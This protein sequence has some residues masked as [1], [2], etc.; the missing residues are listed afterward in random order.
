MNK[1]SIARY[2]IL[3]TISVASV[4]LLFGEYSAES[5][6]AYI[7][8]NILAKAAAVALAIAGWRLYSEWHP[9]LDLEEDADDDCWL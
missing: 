8:V 5:D 2:F 3:L 6:A 1:T 4:I 9:E 7:A